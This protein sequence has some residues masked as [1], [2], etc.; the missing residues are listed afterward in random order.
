MEVRSELAGFRVD[1]RLQEDLNK[2]KV[3][4][5]GSLDQGDCDGDGG[6]RTCSRG[7]SEVKR[8][9]W[10]W[11]ENGDRGVKAD[12]QISGLSN[13]MDGPPLSE[14]GKRSKCGVT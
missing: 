1:N 14:T 6:N 7:I 8:Q 2:L 5:D 4:T 10:R 13:Q 3:K 9:A 12:S 11:S